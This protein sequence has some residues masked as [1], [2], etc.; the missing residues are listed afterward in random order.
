MAKKRTK[1]SELVKGSKPRNIP[2]YYF[3]QEDALKLHK[4]AT[5][6]VDLYGLH[7]IDNVLFCNLAGEAREAIIEIN[8][9]QE[10]GE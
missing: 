9:P 1:A 2:S 8:D 3:S 5:D 4:I 6:L 10:K 7:L